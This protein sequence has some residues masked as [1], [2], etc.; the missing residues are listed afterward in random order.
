M[1]GVGRG[2][3][4][5]RRSDGGAVAKP[6]RAL[7]E[8]R[9]RSIGNCPICHLAVSG[10]GNGLTPRHGHIKNHWTSNPLW[11]PSCT[12]SGMPLDC[13]QWCGE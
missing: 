6:P 8:R 5:G 7:N 12:G 1:I 3:L 10:V 2:R 4:N 9:K 13:L 11:L